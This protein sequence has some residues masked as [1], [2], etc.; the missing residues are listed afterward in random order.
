V[1]SSDAEPNTGPFG[2]E[3][4]IAQNHSW[5]DKQAR[6]SSRHAR[7]TFK[8]RWSCQP[9]LNPA[10]QRF[11]QLI[12]DKPGGASPLDLND[13]AAD[14]GEALTVAPVMDRLRGIDE[15]AA[16]VREGRRGQAA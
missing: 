5:L 7:L 12:S 2:R 11:R 4:P 3:G 14:P 6:K 1:P 13:A 10:S 9:A 8:R 15:Q 16:K